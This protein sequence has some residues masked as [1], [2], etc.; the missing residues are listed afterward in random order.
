MKNFITVAKYTFL[1]IYRSRLMVSLFFLGIGLLLICYIASEFGYGAAGKISLDVGLGFMSISNLIISIFIGSTL[2][3]KEI[4]QRTLYMVLSKP[5]SR[6]SFLLGKLLGLSS[7]LL[8]NSVFLGLLSVGL[9]KVFGGEINGL[10]GWTF[11][12]SFLEA[13]CVL[14][15]SVLFSLITNTTLTV[16]YSL[17]VFIVGHALNETSK[18]IFTK[19]NPVIDQAVN[20]LFVFIP[21]LYRLNLKEYIVYKQELPLTYLLNTQSY[22]AFYLLALIGILVLVFNKKNLD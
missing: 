1:E 15:F 7:V 18:I 2:M 6:A 9:Y 12:F 5:I 8:I 16:I 4:E 11:Y 21:N 17:I 22:I 19:I 20:L 14:L 13:I 3:G 10:F